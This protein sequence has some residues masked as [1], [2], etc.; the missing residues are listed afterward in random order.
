MRERFLDLLPGSLQ[1]GLQGC[2]FGLCLRQLFLDTGKSVVD[3]LDIA[4]RVF[5]DL[6]GITALP[7]NSEHKCLVE[8]IIARHQSEPVIFA[9][10][11]CR[12]DG[13]QPGTGRQNRRAGLFLVRIGLFPNGN[14]KLI[15]VLVEIR[16]YRLQV[17]FQP[18]HALFRGSDLHRVTL[19]NVRFQTVNL[20]GMA[21]FEKFQLTHL[22][23]QVHLLLDVRIACGQRF[24]FR[25]GKRRIVHIFRRTHRRFGCHDLADELLLILQKLPHVRIKRIFGDITINFH[26]LVL[27]ALT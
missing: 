8:S 26:L 10:F 2:Q 17:S 4:Q 6:N 9:D 23:V 18:G 25:I 13:F 27:V 21:G 15:F 16:F 5:S 12:I 3:T 7:L 11:P 1:L 20:A 14:D 22:N 24:D 19:G